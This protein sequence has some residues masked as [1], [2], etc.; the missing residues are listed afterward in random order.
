[1]KQYKDILPMLEIARLAA[2]KAGDHAKSRLGRVQPEFKLD[3]QIVTEADRACQ[4]LIIDEIQRHFPT[5]GFIGEEGPDGQ[6]LKIHSADDRDTWWIID[7]IDGTRNYAH[8]I[9]LF[10]V[11]LAAVQHGMPIL[12]IIYDPNS[13]MMFEAAGDG[14]ARCNGR[15][16]HH[17]TESLNSNTQIAISGHYDDSIPAGI[18]ILLKTYVC[19]NL[20]S[21][22]LHYAYTAMGSFA[23]AYSEKV[24]LW[25]LAAGAVINECA[26]AFLGDLQGR[27]WFPLSCKDYDGQPLPTLNAGRDILPQLLDIFSAPKG[28]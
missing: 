1:M 25:D 10:A 12:G 14:P 11:S 24:R 3:D 2:R 18:S 13:D 21:A 8:Q 5:H 27:S 15:E 6:M 22:A 9:P 28:R 16:F 17:P 26:G 20:G 23:A 19:M 7:P 4:Q